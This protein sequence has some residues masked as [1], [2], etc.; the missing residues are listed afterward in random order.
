[1][2]KRMLIPLDGSE[3]AETMFPY[4][5]ELGG[6]LGLDMTFLYVCSQHEWESPAV[7]RAYVEHMAENIL[8]QARDMQKKGG[9]QKQDHLTKAKGELVVGHPAEE[10][11]RYADE[12]KANLILMAT[13]G[14]SGIMRWALGSVT[15]KVLRSSTI[16]VWLVR[17]GA[18]ERETVG[19]NL[20]SKVI[21]SLDG[22]DLAESILPHVEA[23]A[24]QWDDKPMDVVL[25]MVCEPMVIPPVTTLEVEAP[26]N[27]GNMVE[28]HIEYS[29]KAAGEY[30]SGVAKRLKEAGLK[31]STEVKEGIP[32]DVIIDY[33]GEDP[34][35]LIAM[36][37]HGRSGIGRWVF[38]SQVEKILSGAS[39]PVFLVRPPSIDGLPIV[40]TFVGTVR[41]LPPTI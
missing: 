15:D 12:K 29:K 41:S 21:V 33:A 35:S 16:P 18:P 38:G 39:N 17:A 36:A 5:K 34:S 1:M 27:W 3:I 37:T 13:H 4:A 23:L 25:L 11:L 2:Y 19:K 20:V 22:S 6:R 14:R 30:L 28:E 24:K 40:Q 8:E 9:T 7:Y 32:A 31:V 10:I 26:I